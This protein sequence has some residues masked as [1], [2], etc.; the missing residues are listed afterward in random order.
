VLAQ[1]QYTVGLATNL[2]VL[3]A[4]DQ[5]LSTQLQLATQEYQQ[6]INYLNLLRVAGHLTF[7]DAAPTTLPSTEPNDL[8]ETTTPNVVQSTT[9]P[10]P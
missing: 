6:K 5:L 3:T 8:L 1:R 2:D 4:Q 9:E 7:A 10:A